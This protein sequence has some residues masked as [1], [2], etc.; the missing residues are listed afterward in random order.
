MCFYFLLI[1]GIYGQLLSICGWMELCQHSAESTV[2]W[3]SEVLFPSIPWNAYFTAFLHFPFVSRRRFFEIF[4]VLSY[5][6]LCILLHFRNY[7]IRMHNATYTR[8]RVSP[9]KNSREVWRFLKKNIYKARRKYWLKFVLLFFYTRTYSTRISFILFQYFS[10]F[11]RYVLKNIR[12]TVC[13][14]II[15]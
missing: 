3:C 11:M 12:D 7:Y 9:A 10:C 6:I 15:S 2:L 4:L 5:T 8:N 14:Y 1:F 13:K